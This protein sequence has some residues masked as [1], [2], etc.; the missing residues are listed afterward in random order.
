M[1]GGATKGGG[2]CREM[3]LSRVRRSVSSAGELEGWISGA[4]HWLRLDT[5]RFPP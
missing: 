2:K 1:K 4:E 3:R 5:N